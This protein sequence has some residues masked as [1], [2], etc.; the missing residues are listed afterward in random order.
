M[1]LKFFYN[2]I[3]DINIYIIGITKIIN[4]SKKL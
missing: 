4:D 3:N 1:F 2:I